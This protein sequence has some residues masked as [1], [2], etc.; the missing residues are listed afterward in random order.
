MLLVCLS[1]MPWTKNFG[2]YRSLAI[3]GSSNMNA[4]RL[5]LCINNIFT[6]RKG[7]AMIV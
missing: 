3:Q 1:G 4:M 6:C 2:N 7:T 5:L